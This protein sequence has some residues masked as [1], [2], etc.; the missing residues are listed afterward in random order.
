DRARA[1]LGRRARDESVGLGLPTCC[2]VPMNRAARRRAVEP[3]YE[4]PV[5]LGD[6]GLVAVVDGSLEPLRER[7]GGRAKTQVLHARL[8]GDPH[9]LLLLL[10]VRHL[11]KEPAEMRATAM[12]AGNNRTPLSFSGSRSLSRR[13]S[14]TRL[15]ISSARLMGHP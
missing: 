8:S 12:V 6:R 15:R 10:D 14:S 1:L 5:F 2:G 7:L 11:V 9:A 4:P 3:R 13:R